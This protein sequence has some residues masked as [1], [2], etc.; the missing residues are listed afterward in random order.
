MCLISSPVERCP[1]SG[2]GRPSSGRSFCLQARR[3]H[4]RLM[5]RLNGCRRHPLHCRARHPL[6]RPQSALWCH[7]YACSNSVRP[8][9]DKLRLGPRADAPGIGAHRGN[10]A[11]RHSQSHKGGDRRR[12]T[13]CFG[14]TIEDYDSS[15]PSA[16]AGQPL[17]WVRN[18]RYDCASAARLALS[19]EAGIG[20][21]SPHADR[22]SRLEFRDRSAAGGTGYAPRYLGAHPSKTRP[23]STHLDL[24]ARRKTECLRMT[25]VPPR[26]R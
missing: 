23:Y 17:I 19:D 12:L 26:V 18:C 4:R 13:S 2:S 14:G 8:N 15:R 10:S 1:I 11:E 9:P 20:R 3:V 22:E 6:I 16:T 25:V 7:R 21:S 5:Y 24:A